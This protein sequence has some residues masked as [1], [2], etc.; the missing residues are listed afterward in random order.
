MAELFRSVKDTPVFTI[1]GLLGILAAGLA[2]D[3][4]MFGKDTRDEEDDIPPTR[5][6]D[7]AAGYLPSGPMDEGNPISDDLDDPEDEGL[8]LWGGTADDILSGGDGDDLILGGDGSD[9]IDGRDG[10][11]VIEAGSGNDLVHAGGGFDTVYAGAGDDTVEG[12]DGDDL[13]D[14]GDGADWLAGHSGNDSLQGA[15][16][17]DSLLGGEGDDL[18]DGGSGADWLAGG[19]GND[20]LVAGSGSDTLDGGA[21]DDWLSGLDGEVDDF[22]E[23]YLNGGTGNDVLVL[24][25]GDHAF[26]DSGED[27]FILHDWLIEGGVAHISDYDAGTDQLIVVYDRAAHPDPLLSIEVSADGSQS[28]LLLDG[29]AVATIAGDPLSLADVTLKTA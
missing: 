1:L 29:S 26:G 14:G 16:G 11:D 6:G 20:S 22:V 9:L 3:V 2:A 8:V 7:A 28:T 13:I 17:D 4:V 5:E 23:D 27:D 10:D 24:G 12:Q 25:S 18:L 15:T 21:G 19:Y